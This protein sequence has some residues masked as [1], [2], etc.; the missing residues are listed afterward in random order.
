MKFYTELECFTYKNFELH[1]LNFTCEII[2]SYVEMEHF[3]CEKI[4]QT[5]CEI[6][7]ELKLKATTFSTVYKFQF[8]R[9]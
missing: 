2:I 1:I 8:D 3:T 7:G 4:N 5:I 9:I 6:L